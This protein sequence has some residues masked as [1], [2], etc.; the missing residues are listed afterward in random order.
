MTMRHLAIT[1]V[2]LLV[3]TTHELSDP[4]RI[5]GLEQARLDDSKINGGLDPLP[6]VKSVEVSRASPDDYTYNHHVDLAAWKRRLY[7]AWNQC[8]KDEDVWPSREVYSTSGDGEKW[9]APKEL[10]PQ[11]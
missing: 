2:L 1:A 10:F 6:G 3:T 8:Q 4:I 9:D 7:L 11:G 5:E